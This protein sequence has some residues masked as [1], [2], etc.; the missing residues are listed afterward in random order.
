MFH[1]SLSFMFGKRSVPSFH[2]SCYPTNMSDIFQFDSCDLKITYFRFYF[3]SVLHCEVE[4]LLSWSEWLRRH[5]PVDT[6]ATEHEKEVSTVPALQ[7]AKQTT[8]WTFPQWPENSNSLMLLA[9]ESSLAV[10]SPSGSETL[11]AG[12][13]GNAGC[14]EESCT[15]PLKAGL[16]CREEEFSIFTIRVKIFWSKKRNF[17][18]QGLLAGWLILFHLLGK[19]SVLIFNSK[20]ML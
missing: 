19:L 1:Y 8:V 9:L 5:Y 2:H 20:H 4:Y 3:I 10:C 16:I 15:G 14:G 11:A 18:D 7:P 13:N 17:K 12:Q 6:L